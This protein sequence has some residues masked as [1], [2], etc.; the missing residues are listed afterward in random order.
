MCPKQSL[1]VLPI[2]VAEK[3]HVAKCESL[4]AVAGRQ[5]QHTD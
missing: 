5:P 2:S 4:L 3:R 1:Q